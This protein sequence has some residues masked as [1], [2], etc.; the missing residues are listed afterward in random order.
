MSKHTP[1]PWTYGSKSV[2]HLEPG[3]EKAICTIHGPRRRTTP[4]KI[5]ERNA[6]ANLIAAAPDLFEVTNAIKMALDMGIPVAEILAP[7]SQIRRAVD[8]AIA[9]AEGR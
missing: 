6:N 5:Q 4:L 7:G 9:K 8:A 2:W 3:S 1:G